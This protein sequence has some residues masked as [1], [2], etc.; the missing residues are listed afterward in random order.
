MNVEIGT[1][2]A[3]F[4]EKEYINL[5]FVAVWSRRGLCEGMGGQES[6]TVNPMVATVLGSIPASSD[7]VESE[8]RRMKQAVWNKM[9]KIQNNPALKNKRE[10][11]RFLVW[12]TFHGWRIKR[13]RTLRY[14]PGARV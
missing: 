9:L 10:L 2:A 4:P 3:Q 7:T 14:P 5:L 11:K 1:E 13:G 8:E 6:I 12:G